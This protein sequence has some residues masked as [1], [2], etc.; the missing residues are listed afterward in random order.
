MDK[1]RD[2]FVALKRIVMAVT[3]R[4]S[5]LSSSCP[6]LVTDDEEMV[7]KLREALQGLLECRNRHHS[8]SVEWNLGV[9]E[10]TSRFFDKRRGDY[11]N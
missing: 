3:L 4:N 10:L 8:S 1:H 6:I 11:R 5:A 2:I 9:R 7:E